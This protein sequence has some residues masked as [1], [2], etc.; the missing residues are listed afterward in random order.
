M[1]SKIPHQ[2]ADNEIECARCGAV[3]YYE[4]T[5][6]PECG[7]SLYEPEEEADQKNGAYRGATR[8]GILSKIKQ[9]WRRLLRKPSMA[10]KSFEDAVNQAFLFNNLLLK[11]GG[12]RA[13][14]ERLIEFERQQIPHANRTVWLQNAIERWDRDNQ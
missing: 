12:D 6:C 14:V 7:V 5:R 13:V 10:E 4:L 11:V 3:F 2:P 8:E 1:P 9:I